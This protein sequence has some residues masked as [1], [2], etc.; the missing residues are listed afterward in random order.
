LY[1]IYGTTFDSF[2][3]SNVRAYR[4]WFGCWMVGNMSGLIFSGRDIAMFVLATVCRTWV[5][6]A[7]GD[8][9]S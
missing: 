8:V 5:A 9:G 7:A 2:H 6:R 4:G 1:L 3:V